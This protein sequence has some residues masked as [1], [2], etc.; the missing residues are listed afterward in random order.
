MAGS[1]PASSFLKLAAENKNPVILG[2]DAHEPEAFERRG[3]IEDGYR[4]AG[5]LGLH[6]V[7][8]LI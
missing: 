2:L 1:I 6:V 4:F 3:L 8:E 7:D 5:N